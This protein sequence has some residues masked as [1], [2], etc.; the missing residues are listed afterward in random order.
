MA[1]VFLLRFSVLDPNCGDKW[2]CKQ[3]A[4]NTGPKPISLNI[5]ANRGG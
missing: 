4:L 5:D 3:Y 1:R 2:R